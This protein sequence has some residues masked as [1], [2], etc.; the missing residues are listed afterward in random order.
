MMCT[1]LLSSSA[2]PAAAIGATPIPASANSYSLARRR[3]DAP[4]RLALVTDVAGETDDIARGTERYCKRN[5]V[6]ELPADADAEVD[7]ESL[8]RDPLES[9]AGEHRADHVGSGH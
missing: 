4:T 1:T 6:V 3:D 2:R 5:R 8:E 7:V 9:G